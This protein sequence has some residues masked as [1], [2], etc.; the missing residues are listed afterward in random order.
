MKIEVKKLNRIRWFFLILN[1]LIPVPV[2]ILD[3]AE[4][5]DTPLIIALLLIILFIGWAGALFFFIYKRTTIS[6]VLMK[7][8]VVMIPLLCL[9]YLLTIINFK[10]SSFF[11][12]YLDDLITMALF[13]SFIL[14]A[15]CYLEKIEIILMGLLFT[16]LTGFVLNRA[17]IAVGGVVIVPLGFLF[18]SIGFI[19][20]TFRAIFKRDDNK[21]LRRMLIIFCGIIAALNIIFLIK[22]SEYRPALANI[23]DIIGVIIFLLACLALLIILP[24]SDFTEWTKQHRTKFK[25]IILLPLLF[26][27]L[28]FSLKFLLPENTYRKIFFK[29]YGRKGV[30]YF[31]MKDYR[32]DYSKRE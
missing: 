24:F 12:V 7:T 22:F 20:L 3:K 11:D 21:N 28:I 15:I 9:S 31:D 19:Y 5:G 32:I 14:G 6:R 8:L 23:Y 30:E 1:Y 16:T 18:S 29:E 27:L 2:M 17:G 13:V 26:F 4:L 25:R 10:K